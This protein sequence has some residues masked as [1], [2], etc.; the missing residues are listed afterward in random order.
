M[1]IWAGSASRASHSFK[2]SFAG[3][4]FPFCPPFWGKWGGGGVEREKKGEMTKN[5][6]YLGK[7]VQISSK[8]FEGKVTKWLFEIIS[9]G[10]LG[11]WILCFKL[12]ISLKF[13]NHP[14][15]SLVCATSCCSWA[16]W[17]SCCLAGPCPTSPSASTSQK[18]RY[19]LIQY[20]G[21]N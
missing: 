13:S 8:G 18:Y 12:I 9:H 19:V 5:A 4:T 7:L 6:K 17:W 20:T 2:I 1:P 3:I 16:S 21:S 11:I 10:K 14:I 15:F